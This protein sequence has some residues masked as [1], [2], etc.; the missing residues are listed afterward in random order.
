MFRTY[1][2]A[3]SFTML[4][5]FSMLRTYGA[6]A[7]AG[8]IIPPE[9]PVLTPTADRYSSVD[10]LRMCKEKA[11]RPDVDAQMGDEQWYRLLTEA[12]DMFL[13]EIAD[14]APDALA[15][16]YATLTTADGGKSYQLGTDVYGEPLMPLGHVEVWAR[17]SGGKELFASSYDGG[18]DFVIDG[19]NIRMPNGR[20]RL[21]PNGGPYA[22]WLGVPPAITANQQPIIFPRPM[23]V[24]LVFYAL[25]LWSERGARRDPAP[26]R[27]GFRR[28]WL[29]D[30]DLGMLGWLSLIH[31]SEPTRPC[32]TSRMPSSA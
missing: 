5:S 8:V 9:P 7:S 6:A 13:P 28:E 16:Q 10:L 27:N 18:G 15:G 20:A 2:I 19:G 11:G 14:R 30:P 25:L 1:S 24:C 22:R 23:R 17:A 31:I 4:R 12:Q 3:R 21:F 26:W 29:G 32:G